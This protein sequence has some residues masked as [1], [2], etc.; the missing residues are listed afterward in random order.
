MPE[1]VHH[2]SLFGAAAPWKHHSMPTTA[3]PATATATDADL[4]LLD[5][6]WRAANYLS[7]G[8]IYLLDNPL[9]REPLH[10]DHVKP[11]LLGHWGTTPG[12]NL[13]YAHLNR[14][15][16]ARDADVLYVCGPGHGGPGMVA[17]TWLEGTY[18]EVYPEIGRTRTACGRLFRQFSFP[19]GIPS[20]AAPETPGLDQ[21]GRR[22]GLRARPRLRRRLRQPRPGGGVRDR[23]RRGRDRPARRGVAL[24]QVPRP[25]APTGRCCRSC[26]STGT[27]SPTPPCSP[28]SPTTS[29]GRCS[30]ATATASTWWR[31]TTRR[32]STAPWPTR[33]TPCFDE[34][35]ASPSRR[36]G[37]ASR[38]RAPSA[39]PRWPM[40]VLR[41]PKGWTGPRASTACRSR[42]PSG[43]TRCRWPGWPSNPEHLRMLE[44]WMRSYRP[45]E[46]FDGGRP[47]ARDRGAVA[48]GRQADGRHALRQRRPAAHRPRPAATSATTPSTCR[49]P[50]ARRASR[51]ASSAAG[52]AT[53]SSATRRRSA[54]WAPT[55][56]RRTA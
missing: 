55:R 10:L 46:L 16:R 29:S 19:G 3:S 35:A 2:G 36:G 14:V 30:R 26:T 47:A 34:I 23:R 11:R 5:A 33:S 22:A 4:E 17:N 9:L 38:R 20:H 24:E 1:H 25:R 31:A 37:R 28:A 42:A 18:S 40:I 50:G 39:R 51:P 52:C 12:L 43:P 27:R 6:W 48:H 41:T 45:D 8:Q 49:R 54:S 53:W 15:I 32:P 7:V 21:R 44:E 56:P 13:I